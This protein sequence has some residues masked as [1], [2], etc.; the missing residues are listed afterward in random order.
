M[1]VMNL[2]FE[3]FREIVLALDFK[4]TTDLIKITDENGYNLLHSA[5]FYNSFKIAN[6]L[7]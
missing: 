7:I 5:T 1:A 6:F 3:T 4:R 2:T